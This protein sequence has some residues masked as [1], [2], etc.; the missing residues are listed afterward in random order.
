MVFMGMAD[1]LTIVIPCKNEKKVIIN[2]LEKIIDCGYKIIIAD[3]S[4]DEITKKLL[5]EFKSNHPKKIKIISGGLPSIARNNGFK[6]VESEYVLFL[7]SDVFI[8]DNKLINTALRK[9][10]GGNYDLLTTKF[11]TIEKNMILFI[12]FLI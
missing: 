10:V 5:T 8:E 2:C 12:N 4:D 11:R 6:Y 3:S 9:I 1:Q 7:D